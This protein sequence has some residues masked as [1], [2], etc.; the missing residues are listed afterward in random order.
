M[1]TSTWH[2]DSWP[3]IA[4]NLCSYGTNRFRPSR[5]INIRTPLRP[6]SKQ[7]SKVR[8]VGRREEPMASKPRPLRIGATTVSHPRGI[9]WYN[10]VIYCKTGSSRLSRLLQEFQDDIR[11]ALEEQPRGLQQY[12]QKA[13]RWNMV[14]PLTIELTRHENA[15]RCKKDISMYARFLTC[16]VFQPEKSLASFNILLGHS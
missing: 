4:S 9:T 13:I 10:P 3:W 15:K 14:K 12:N 1:T 5:I 2:P 8:V 7:R 11:C 16:Q 6:C